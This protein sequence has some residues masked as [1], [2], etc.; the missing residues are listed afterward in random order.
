MGDSL[1]WERAAEST[2]AVLEDLTTHD[3]TDMIAQPVY[4]QWV[5]P[6]YRTLFVDEAQDLSPMQHALA[7]GSGERVIAVGDPRQSI[8]GFAGADV[9]SFPNMTE[10]LRERETGCD[11]LPLSCCFRCPISHLDLAQILV[12]TITPR[13]DADKGTLRNASVDQL[14]EQSE[15]GD[16]VVCR[17][18]APLISLAFTFIRAR[19]PVMVRG[20]G[21]G[22]GLKALVKRMRATSITGLVDNVKRWRGEQVELLQSEDGTPDEA[23]QRITDQ[24]DSILVLAYDSKTV[25]ELTQTI[26]ELFQDK[27][28][29]NLVCLSTIHR[30]KGLEA[31]RV[32]IYE[33][34]L[35]PS[36]PSA[37]QELNLLYVALTRAKRELYLVDHETRRKDATTEQW[38]KNVANGFS[39]WEL[40]ERDGEKKEV[41]C[42]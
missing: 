14:L 34:G 1:F 28:P 38:V 26:D 8:M 11:V 40:I 31:N 18:T 22:D 30:A 36:R 19:K 7:L 12:P 35:M 29:N 33:P 42:E 27:E 39:R 25:E 37:V 15:P 16:L 10:K 13:P 5:V 6:Q 9:N 24:A 21:I 32:W 4:H 20:R 41:S 3:F 23:L 17:N 2:V